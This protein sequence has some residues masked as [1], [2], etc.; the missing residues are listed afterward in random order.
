MNINTIK[1]VKGYINNYES[2]GGNEDG[3]CIITYI[4]SATTFSEY[5]QV[6]IKLKGLDEDDGRINKFFT[7]ILDSNK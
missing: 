5:G 7:N 1:I 3:E 4:P 6:C 2:A